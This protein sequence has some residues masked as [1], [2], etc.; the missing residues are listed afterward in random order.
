MD[1]RNNLTEGE[2]VDERM[3]GNWKLEEKFL[4]TSPLLYFSFFFLS[5]FCYLLLN[6]TFTFD[7]FPL[8]SLL[9]SSLCIS[10]M[11]IWPH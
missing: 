1:L 10:S 6:L 2:K 5:T 3:Y 11:A 7:F 9:H 4:P 8:F